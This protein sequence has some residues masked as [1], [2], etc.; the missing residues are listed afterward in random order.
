MS[1]EIIAFFV[2]GTLKRRECRE[3]CWPCRP[4]AVLRATAAGSLWQVA[5]YPAMLAQGE[6]RVLGEIWLF[7]AHSEQRILNAL[8]EVEGY[9]DLFTRET[10]DCA[11]LDGDPI[12][13]TTYLYNQPI[14]P[15]HH[16]VEANT[17]GLIEWTGGRSA[18]QFG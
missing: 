7:P 3:A 12:A 11:T 18:G 8:D 17:E 1:D 6:T 14:L 10:I 9:P 15:S 13:A 2:Y 4:V 5:D 16:P